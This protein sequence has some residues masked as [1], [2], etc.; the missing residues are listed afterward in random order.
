MSTTS[1]LTYMMNGTERTVTGTPARIRREA[2]NVLTCW[3][4]GPVTIDGV[5]YD[6]SYDIDPTFDVFDDEED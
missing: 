4:D 3:S 1:T 6:D 2:C 5:S